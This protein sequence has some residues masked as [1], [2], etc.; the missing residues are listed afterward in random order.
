MPG[1]VTSCAQHH[2][3]RRTMTEDTGVDRAA[4]TRSFSG[5]VARFRQ[6][7]AENKMLEAA[8]YSE[9]PV[10]GDLNQPLVSYIEE[11]E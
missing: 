4:F 8:E 10:L 1:A 9:L 7:I 3:D 11:A 6:V 5:H 2:L